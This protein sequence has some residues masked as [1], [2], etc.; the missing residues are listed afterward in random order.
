MASSL[1]LAAACVTALLYISLATG[2]GYTEEIR[3]PVEQGAIAQCAENSEEAGHTIPISVWLEMGPVPQPLPLFSKIKNLDGKT[4]A[5]KDLLEFEQV[6]V[7]DWWPKQGETLVWEPGFELQWKEVTTTGATNCVSHTTST[8]D[9]PEIT[10]LAAYVHA[11]R[12]IEVKLEVTGSHLFQVYLDGTMVASKSSSGEPGKDPANKPGSV[13][14]EVELETGKHLLLVKSLRDPGNSAPCQTSATL[15]MARDWPEAAVEIT[16]SSKQ[17]MNIKHLLDTP[18]I[19]SVSISPEGDLVAL[20]V[21]RSLPPSNESESWLE[22]RR[23]EDGSL[24][25]TYRG[26]TSVSGLRWAPKG[27]M[28][29]YTSSAKDGR[30]LW[31]VDLDRGT[32]TPLLENV[33]NLGGHSWAPDGSFIIYSMTEKHKPD[34]SGIKLLKGM[35]DRQPGWRDRSFLYLVNVS[36][37][38]KQR[39]TA[40]ALTTRLNDVSPNGD[41]ILFTRWW[42]DYSERPYEK[43]EFFALNLPDMTVDPL[44]TCNWSGSAH[45]SP[46]G[47]R[48]L[49]TGPPAMFGEKGVN[50]LDG[51]IPNDY[52]TQ[53]FIY[54]LETKTV[55]PITR[56]F[57]PKIDQA[58]WSKTEDCIYF[59]VT[60]GSYRCLYRYDLEEKCFE[61]IDTDVDVIGRLDIAEHQPVAVYTGSSA[62]EPP[63][64]YVMNLK[65][66]K[67][68]LLHDPAK[69]DFEDVMLGNVERWTFRNKSNVEIEGRVYYP[70][71]FDSRSTYPCIVHYYGGTSPTPRSFGGRY[72]KN[73]YAA[74]GYVVYVLQPSGATGFGQAFSALHVND[75]GII[76]ADEI[77]D[78]VKQF[79]RAHPFVD[80][81]RVG[82]IGASY[83]GFM[84]ML[85]QTRTDM[86]AAAVSHAG[87]SSI[88]SH[89]GEGYWGYAYCAVAAANSFP[90]N[91]KDIFID[92]S[93]LFHAD[94]IKT[95]LLLLHGMADTNVPP[96]ESIQLYTALKLLG[97]D[98][99]LIQIDEQDHQIM[100]YNKR[101]LWTQ[102]ILAWF[103]RWLKNQPQWWDHM[104][105]EK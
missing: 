73:L 97:R 36:Q 27:R 40:G 43:T 94:K 68:R 28:C 6:N 47:K 60:E 20:A 63:K 37:G 32:V 100:E 74:Q 93:P 30:T 35:R 15:R 86:F 29:S 57:D 44:W 50:V 23:V 1:R 19:S 26:G 78:G 11:R 4:F 98:V 49:A 58:I 102:S 99:E 103:D 17:Y 83:G 39:L 70:P 76:V 89:W 22:L 96:G 2:G 48:L 21:R 13:S 25:H 75:W 66:R 79:L 84:T 42:P 10:Y 38:T 90:W 81:S 62:S 56:E 87:I 34:K 16:T 5:L 72:P 46:D 24:L 59:A 41:R 14:K 9:A 101:I 82:C 105:G 33:E 104:Y 54:D 92:Q 12:W 88:S 53:A 61:R 67:P 80:E 45:W 91:R 85:L 18:S 65:A 64:A 8:Q 95:P 51:L 3:E 55:E 52:D 77:I 71:D 7:K 31:I 69:K